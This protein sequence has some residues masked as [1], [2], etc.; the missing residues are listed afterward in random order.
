[1]AAKISDVMLGD[2][3]NLIP[4]LVEAKVGWRTWDVKQSFDRPVL[5]SPIFK[6]LWPW[7]FERS[8]QA[9]CEH[10]AKERTKA[11][12]C[13]CGIN[14]FHSLQQLGCEEYVDQIVWGQVELWGEVREYPGGYRAEC[15]RPISLWI[16]PEAKN[17]QELAENL[18]ELYGCPA[19]VADAPLEL[20]GGDEDDGPITFQEGVLVAIV[21]ATV[22]VWI[23]LASGS[24]I[25]YVPQFT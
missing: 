6:I 14:A 19:V 18:A 11:D 23:Y 15:A 20:L 17:A 9:L 3:K 25:T 5:M 22:I 16:S 2:M 8:V 12:V 24:V 21:L 7:R 1:M 10:S 13:R 4:D